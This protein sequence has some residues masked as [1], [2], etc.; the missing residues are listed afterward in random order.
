[1]ID[2]CE[3]MRVARVKDDAHPD[4][5][6]YSPKSSCR[7]RRQHC[8]P[9]WSNATMSPGFE[10]RINPLR[11]AHG[12][13]CG[14]RIVFP[15]LQRTTRRPLSLPQRAA[16]GESQ[17][18]D[19]QRGA[20]VT[21]VAKIRSCQISG[22]DC[23]RPG[24]DARHATFFRSDQDSGSDS[25]SLGPQPAPSEIPARCRC[26]RPHATSPSPLP[27]TP[28]VP[29]RSPPSA[30]ATRITGVPRDQLRHANST[31]AHRYRSHA[32]N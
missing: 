11:V 27:T 28:L 24:N 22:S 21:L 19:N 31:Q 14:I 12:R 16:V 17:A 9:A 32:T 6:R 15:Q 29:S 5:I 13:R 25:A 20:F 30:C 26:I 18:S 1:M 23:P 3:D 2:Q 4:S 10:T 8:S 7:F